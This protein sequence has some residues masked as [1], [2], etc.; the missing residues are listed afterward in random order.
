MEKLGIK[1]ITAISYAFEENAY[2]A[3]LADDD[4]CVIV[5]PGIDPDELLAAIA[6]KHLKP[7]GI[8]ITHGHY[9]HI[10]GIPAILAH[11]SDCKI[12]ASFEEAA[13]LIDPDQNL[14]SMFGVPMAVN[15]ADRIIEDGEE[16]TV[17][18]IEFQAVKIPG[19]SRGHLAYVVKHTEPLDIFVG[20]II[21]DGSIGRGDFPDGNSLDL[22]TGIK[23][24][25]FGFPDDTTLYPGH[26]CTT[27]IGK[28]KRSNPYLT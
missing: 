5:D 21:F 16:F 18:G 2:I 1:I 22:I 17:A 27:T 15:S 28:E 9:D 12:Y 10:G 23:S 4:R 8:L 14:S 13:K 19:H 6:E 7:E 26:G 24:K 11:W 3:H 25:L 20:D